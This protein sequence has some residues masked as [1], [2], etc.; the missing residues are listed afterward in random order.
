M[1]VSHLEKPKMQKTKI[2]KIATEQQYLWECFKLPIPS[3][4]QLHTASMPTGVRG[5]TAFRSTP[6]CL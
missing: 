5:L 6:A 4:S 2:H 3:E 1:Y